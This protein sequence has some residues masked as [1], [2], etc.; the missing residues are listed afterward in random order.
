MKIKLVRNLCFSLAFILSA[1]SVFA[2]ELKSD[3]L[4]YAITIP[5][6]WT[7]TFQ[8]SAGFSVASQDTK[9]TIT[10]LIRKVSS[11]VIDSNSIGEFERDMLKAGSQ[12]VS[13][14]NFTVDGVPAY[15]TIHSIGKAPFA[16]SFIVHSMIA[17]HKLYH[18][19]A[20]HGGGDV[21]QD[22]DMLEAFAS[23][24]FLQ[25][26]KPPGSFGFGS[27][28]VK[29]AILGIIIVAV[30]LVIRSRRA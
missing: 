13:S 2:L 12:K 21:T 4:N 6:G 27:L 23:F 11:A 7:L 30:F 10:L 17:N 15:E 1:F 5:D 19:Q 9:K 29:I 8:N 14:T 22:S 25:P 16:S 18:L 28:G 26:P 24:H 20:M 3:D